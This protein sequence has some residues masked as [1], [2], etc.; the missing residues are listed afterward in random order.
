MNNRSPIVQ[1]FSIS[2]AH[3]Q[4]LQGC[5]PAFGPPLHLFDLIRLERVVID[6]AKEFAD[7]QLSEAKGVCPQ[8]RVPGVSL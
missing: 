3:L 8:F 1:G 7:L 4:E 2:E 5:C 6:V